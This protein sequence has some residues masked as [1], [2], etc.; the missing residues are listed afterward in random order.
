MNCGLRQVNISLQ[1]ERTRSH[2][3]IEMNEFS[4]GHKNSER[5][6]II[7]WL[8]RDGVSLEEDKQAERSGED[9]QREAK[10]CSRSGP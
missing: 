7:N 4:R 1:N 5:H 2:H 9:T 10:R 8:A 6:D 3:E